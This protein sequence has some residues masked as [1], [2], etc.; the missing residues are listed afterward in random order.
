MITDRISLNLLYIYLK[1]VEANEGPIKDIII[2][3]RSNREDLI[4]KTLPRFENLTQIWNFINKETSPGGFDNIHCLN[5]GLYR[6]KSFIV[7]KDKNAKVKEKS[8]FLVRS[9]GDGGFH[10]TGNLRGSTHKDL[11]IGYSPRFKE[12][13]KKWK[14]FI[15]NEY[16]KDQVKYI[17]CGYIE[18]YFEAAIKDLKKLYD[19]YRENRSIITKELYNKNIRR[20]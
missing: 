11:K 18:V 2:S 9:K 7:D 14:E 17:D 5:L 16:I 19:K 3:H 10:T 15:L 12:V 1:R 13:E 4:E 8:N 20:K 6:L